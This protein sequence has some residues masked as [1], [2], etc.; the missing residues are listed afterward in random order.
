MGAMV[1]TGAKE[2]PF[3]LGTIKPVF[4]LND[5]GKRS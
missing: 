5:T 4:M 2:E 1:A 3:I